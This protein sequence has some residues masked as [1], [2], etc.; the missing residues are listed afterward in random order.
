MHVNAG[1]A[2][3]NQEDVCGALLKKLSVEECL[4]DMMFKIWSKEEAERSNEISEM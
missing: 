4:M 2:F 1:D 3:T